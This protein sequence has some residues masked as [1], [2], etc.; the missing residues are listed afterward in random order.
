MFNKGTKKLAKSTSKL[1]P[2]NYQYYNFT[3]VI[4]SWLKH[5][6]LHIKS[7]AMKHCQKK[8][9]QKKYNIVNFPYSKTEYILKQL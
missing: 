6:K 2:Y 3:A 8:T 9:T 7:V 1:M 4:C 5:M